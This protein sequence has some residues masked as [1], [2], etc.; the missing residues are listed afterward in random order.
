VMGS[1]APTAGMVYKLVEVDGRPV[2]KRSEHKASRGG[3]KV[4]I[5]RHRATGTATEEWV[6]RQDR[7][8]ELQPGEELL[9]VPLMRGGVRADGLPA[10]AES[11]ARLR[12]R[13]VTIPWDGLKLSHGEPAIPT[14]FE[15]PDHDR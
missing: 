8:P 13:I 9:Q 6:Y 14:I 2:A 1:G 11:R 4:A 15:E 5:R 3:R 7:A 12:E 10:L